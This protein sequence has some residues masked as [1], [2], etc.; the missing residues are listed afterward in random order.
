MK[1]FESVALAFGELEDAQFQRYIP[2]ALYLKIQEYQDGLLY[3]QWVERVFTDHSPPP[4]FL[5]EWSIFLFMEGK[6]NEAEVKLV[7]TYFSNTYVFDQ[8][9]GRPIV[10][11]D[12][13]EYAEF[14][15]T[16]FAKSFKYSCEQEDLAP[17][18]KWFAEFEQS[19]KFRSVAEKYVKSQVD[20]KFEQ[21]PEKLS[22]LIHADY[23][24]MEE[25]KKLNNVS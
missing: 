6:I 2:S 25:F 19:E 14:E 7:E 13:V 23:E 17:F 18:V 1:E 8:F 15:H 5:F 16:A 24:L 9:F 10:H 3:D 11:I 21:D 4:D 22:I 12:K 20:S